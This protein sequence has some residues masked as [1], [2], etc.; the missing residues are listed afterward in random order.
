VIVPLA[1]SLACRAAVLAAWPLVEEET[2]S[3]FV[4]GDRV[5]LHPATDAWMAGDRYGT[6]AYGS[7]HA[8]H[9]LV[10]CD[11]SD[12]IRRM[13]PQDITHVD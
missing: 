10:H 9:V 3:D 1:S 2:M 7:K 8:T 4:K 13:R 6:V 11:R 5:Q 12:R